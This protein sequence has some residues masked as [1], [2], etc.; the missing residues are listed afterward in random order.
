MRF[1][2]MVTA[3]LASLTAVAASAHDGRRFEIKVVDDQLVAHGYH[4][5]GIDDGAGVQRDYYNALH[6]HWTNNTVGSGATATLPGFDILG[7]APG[8]AG[9]D[10]D[11]T[12]TGAK[13]WVVTPPASG[14]M[15]HGTH[16][17][18]DPGHPEI[19][20]MPLDGELL[21]LS[22]G[23]TGQDVTTDS[24]GTIDLVTGWD[25]VVGS[26]NGYDLDFLY[27]IAVAPTDTI[28]VLEGVL[29][30]DAPGIAASETVYTI[31]SPTG[32]S[33]HANSLALE[34]YLGTPIPEP[35]TVSLAAL[36]GVGWLVRRRAA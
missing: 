17:G 18:H 2:V 36:V 21:G 12:L 20:L 16:G 19:H 7:E 23:L 22:Y 10:V 4:S 25:G 13:K 35:M 6:A 33:F 24:P 29:S 34:A 28:F 3:A 27:Q 32:H 5:A 30:T 14:H 15:G 26:G 9:Y 11:Y 1:D 8:L 31:L